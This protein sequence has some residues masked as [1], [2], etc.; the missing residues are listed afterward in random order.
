MP[1][2]DYHEYSRNLRLGILSPPV[3]T[4]I[5]PHP[6]QGCQKSPQGMFCIIY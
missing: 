5:S 2:G 1:F 3:N 4:R 6:G